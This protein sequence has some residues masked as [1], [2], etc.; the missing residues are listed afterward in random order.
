MKQ[1]VR[2]AVYDQ[3]LGLEAYCFAGM[4]RPFPNHFHEYYV[5]GLVER[6]RRVLSCRNREYDLGPGD[7]L[8]LHPGDNHACSQSDGGTL[9]YRG[10][11]IPR[12][13][14]LALTEEVTGKRELPGFS[15]V[16]LRDAEAVCCLRALHEQVMEGGC[17]FGKEERLLVLIAALLE[18]CGQPLAVCVPECREEIEAA[19]RFME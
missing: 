16:V 14:M 7:L 3:A 19:C 6:G 9:D 17:S 13:T 1:E 4:T 10:F 12:E 8:L 18:R 2:A 15:K 5:L 11:H